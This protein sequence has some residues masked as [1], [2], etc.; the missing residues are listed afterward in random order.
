MDNKFDSGMLIA[1]ANASFNV[2]IPQHYNG[3]AGG[4]VWEDMMGEMAQSLLYLD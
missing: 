1:I 3:L 2:G 4:T